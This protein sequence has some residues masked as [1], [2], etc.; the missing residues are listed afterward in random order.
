MPP[1]ESR[2]ELQIAI[3]VMQEQ[4]KAVLISIAEVKVALS[5]ITED[6]VAD[7]QNLHLKVAK[8]ESETHLELQRLAMDIAWFKKIA[9]LGLT[10]GTGSAVAVVGGWL[11]SLFS[12]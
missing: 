10:L 2:S 8:L 7:R 4:H 5:K 6:S 12:I 1:S 11:K 3:A 9:S